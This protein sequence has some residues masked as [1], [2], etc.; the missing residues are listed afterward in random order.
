[1]RYSSGRKFDGSKGTETWDILGTGAGI[2]KS[3]QIRLTKG[4]YKGE[5]LKSLLSKGMTCSDVFERSPEL[6][7]E[8]RW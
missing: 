2:G 1:M 4:P 8:S 7:V 3:E 5:P 6:H